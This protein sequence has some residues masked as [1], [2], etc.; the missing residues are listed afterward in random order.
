MT[1]RIGLL[2]YVA[3]AGAAL[4][5]AALFGGITAARGEGEA[6]FRIDPPSQNATLTQTEV[7]FTVMLDDAVNLAAWEFRFAFDPDVITYKN[8]SPSGF[9]A[10]T[11]RTQQCLSPDI[12][13]DVDIPEVGTGLT[14]VQYGCNTPGSSLP[15][16]NGDGPLATVRFTPKGEGVTP[17][18]CNKL[19]VTDA[20]SDTPQAVTQPCTGVIKV[21]SSSSTGGNSNGNSGNNGNGSTNNS[22]L[23]PTPTPNVRVLTPTAIPNAPTQQALLTLG[24]PET[25]FDPGVTGSAGSTGAS[26]GGNSSSGSGI[27]GG[28]PDGI[29]SGVRAAGN[30]PVAGYGMA[31]DAVSGLSLWAQLV[32]CV[33]VLTFATGAALYRQTRP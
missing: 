31:R 24:T 23:E 2:P 33:G 3:L 22:Q 1:R 12:E 30:F 20:L 16:V 9:L 32:L 25:G 27:L 6:T 21:T 11:G 15:G 19:E 13:T 29:V 14:T 5:V 28:A 7:A 26:G 17:L 8:V 4:G 10:Q 18:V